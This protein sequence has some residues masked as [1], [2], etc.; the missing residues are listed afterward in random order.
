VRNVGAGAGGGAGAI[1]GAGA[2][3]VAA[4]AFGTIDG[5][6]E[7]GVSRR[8]QEKRTSERTIAVDRRVTRRSYGEKASE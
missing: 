1:V 3:A 6:S 8:V 7:I 5:V 4:A 2:I